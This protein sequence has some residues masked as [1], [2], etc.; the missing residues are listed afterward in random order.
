MDYVV[1]SIVLFHRF[2][3]LKVSWKLDAVALPYNLRR[4]RLEESW[5]EASPG[6]KISRLHLNQWLGTCGVH[7]SSHLYRWL[8]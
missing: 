6:K 5:L 8:K 2:D 1:N 7:L 3:V 4:L